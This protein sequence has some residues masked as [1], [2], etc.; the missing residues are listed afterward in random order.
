MQ[1]VECSGPIFSKEQTNN[2]NF[3]QI[4]TTGNLRLPWYKSFKL[5]VDARFCALDVLLR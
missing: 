2:I 1:K 3:N 4:F 5:L